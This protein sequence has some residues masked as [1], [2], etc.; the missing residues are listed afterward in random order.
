METL[1][2]FA[3]EI[4]NEW[5]GGYT[6]NVV[7][8]NLI[9]YLNGKEVASMDKRYQVVGEDQDAVDQLEYMANR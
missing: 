8:E 4:N 2:K 5:I 6:A 7:G 3:N 1:T 9:V